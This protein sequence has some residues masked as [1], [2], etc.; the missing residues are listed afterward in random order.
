MASIEAGSRAAV[1]WLG[2]IGRPVAARALPTWAGVAIAA[3]VVMGGNG[4]SPR[5][6][7]GVVEAAPRGW[8]I[9]GGA[10]L[11]LTA[12]AVRAALD[13][14]GA[15]YLRALP[16]GPAGERATIVV[17]AATVHAPWVVV[18]L[19]G[20]GPAIGLAAWAAMTAASLVLVGLLARVA[21]RARP[22][23]WP[24]P[25]RA[26]AGVHARSL[27][28]RRGSALIAGAGMAMLGGAL[29]GVMVGHEAVTATDAAVLAGATSTLALA[30]ALAAATASV[31]DSDR[32]L[33]WL[34]S[35]SGTGASARRGAVA[36]VLGGLGLAAAGVAT[37]AAAAVGA[38]FV[39]AMAGAHAL[40]GLGLGLGGVA[41]AAWA[42]RDGGDDPVR[43][44]GARVAIGLVG[45]GVV[46]LAACGLFGLA[47]LAGVLALGAG[48]A[49]GGGGRGRR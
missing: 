21:P 12:A 36:L 3:G 34:A 2:T 31:A 35:S 43:I 22:P 47:G 6:L 1:A 28:R 37:V 19:I 13:A 23:R 38:R 44:D 10:W 33:D 48:L 27:V 24:G 42:R 30:I 20:A 29:A 8:A 7:A 14:P 32:Q 5:D 25:V 17:A 16:G 39:P 41:A 11:L 26:L 49:A 45:L 40:V 46:D 15:A 9:L 4:L 18:W